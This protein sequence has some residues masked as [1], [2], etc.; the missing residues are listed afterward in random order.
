MRALSRE[1]GFASRHPRVD[2]FSD[3]R[4][5]LARSMR[6]LRTTLRTLHVLAIAAYYGG[7]VFS[8][9]SEDG[10][11]FLAMELVEGNTLGAALVQQ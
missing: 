5:I 7:H 4:A 3:C 2:P 6:P 10:H 8:V 11:H 1:G 9:E